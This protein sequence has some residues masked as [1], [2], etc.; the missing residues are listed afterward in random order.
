MELRIRHGSVAQRKDFLDKAQ[1][2]LAKTRSPLRLSEV[3]DKKNKEKVLFLRE[4][5]WGEFFLEKLILT[6]QE[7]EDV[8]NEALAAIELAFFLPIQESRAQ[9]KKVSE[10]RKKDCVPCLDELAYEILSESAKISDDEDVGTDI[11]AKLCKDLLK[12]HVIG[13]DRCE[14]KTRVSNPSNVATFNG[15]FNMPEGISISTCP[16]LQVIAHH[17]IVGSV[18]AMSFPKVVPYSPLERAS[19]AFAIAWAAWK[20]PTLPCNSAKPKS[21]KNEITV[22]V[23]NLESQQGLR[24]IQ[25]LRCIPDNWNRNAR[26]PLA[27]QVKGFWENFY[28]D[29]CGSAKGKIVLGLYP[30]CYTGNST[31]GGRK[32]PFYSDE[33]IQGAIDAAEK[34]RSK[35]TKG[36]RGM[37]SI[38]FAGLDNETYERMTKIMNPPPRPKI[39]DHLLTPERI[40]LN[41]RNNKN[42][43]NAVRLVP[44]IRKN[45]NLYSNKKGT[46]SDDL[47]I[48]SDSE[49][50][51]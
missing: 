16:A 7:I 4:R 6:P 45:I 50:D 44:E 40:P 1:E 34:I 15:L 8:Q 33:N 28:L 2:L 37:P 19:K 11:R 32:R 18:G 20:L 3:I 30:D 12:W 38:M 9:G 36:E 49:D 14:S 22:N 41:L 25:H 42:L 26:N 48:I 47:E 35:A 13:K 39:P 46:S 21:L 23:Y 31:A 17:T 24:H 5:T 43:Q 27:S 29:V 10:K 51:V